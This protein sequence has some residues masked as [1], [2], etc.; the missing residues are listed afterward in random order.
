M[1]NNDYSLHELNRLVR[2]VLENSLDD[3][4]WVVGELSDASQGYG[5]HF[6]GELIEKE[7]EGN[8]I[9]ARARVT[10]WARMYH[11]I[12][13]RFVRDTGQ[14][15]HAGMKVRL[16]VRITFHEQYGYALNIID[17]DSQYTLGDLAKRRREILERLEKDGFWVKCKN[18]ESL[19]TIHDFGV[20]ICGDLYING[21][22]A[23]K[24]MN[25]FVWADDGSP[26]GT[27][28]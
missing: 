10:C 15:L 20:G 3:E 9:L 2:S 8:R 27:K 14:K 21:Y 23:L 28:I 5:G 26:C 18:K 12:S 16:L 24:F 4:Y 1:A 19:C 13:M 7:E 6:Y 22:D 17:V 25:D 11:M